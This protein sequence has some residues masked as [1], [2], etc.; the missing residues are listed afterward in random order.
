MM[1]MD[2]YLTDDEFKRMLRMVRD[3]DTVTAGHLKDIVCWLRES[4]K[5]MKTMNSE[6]LILFAE[7][8]LS[9]IVS[10][11]ERMTWGILN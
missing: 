4:G 8:L 9:W 10:E 3:S 2:N 11:S 5:S 1:S 6:G 7:T